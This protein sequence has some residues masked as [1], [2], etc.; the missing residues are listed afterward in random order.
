MDSG[1]IPPLVLASGSATRVAMLRAAGLEFDIVHPDVDETA[2][3]QMAVTEDDTVSPGSIAVLLARAK[4]V[5][6]SLRYPHALVIGGDQV[7]ALGHDVIFKAV[8]L[9]GARRTLA[10]LKGQTHSLHAAAALAMDGR[11]DWSAQ[12]TARLT[13]RDFSPAFLD[14]YLER[15]GSTLISSVGC[16]QIEG[17]GLNLFEKVSGHHSTILGL[18]LLALLAELRARGVLLS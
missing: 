11:A 18:P 5:E 10:R 6:V 1:Q 8:D 12:D 4:A 9:D 3:Y 7:L 14:D 16:Y 2:L 15:A 13:M 17:L